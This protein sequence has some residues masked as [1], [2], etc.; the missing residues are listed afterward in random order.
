MSADWIGAAAGFLT[1][2]AFVPQVW[3]TWKTR[4]AEDISMSMFLIFCMGVLCWLIYGISLGS[5]PMVFF[6]A[7][8]LGLALA[9][10]GMKIYFARL[11]NRRL[12]A[13]S[14]RGL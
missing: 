4:S 10:V 14:Q 5:W 11:K 6:N 9:I 8:T 13:A 1:T 12:S 7:I 2:V 3:Q